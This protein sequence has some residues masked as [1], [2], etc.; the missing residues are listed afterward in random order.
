MMIKLNPPYTNPSQSHALCAHRLQLAAFF[1]LFF[2]AGH[3][4]CN[5]GVETMYQMV[6][7]YSHRYK[8]ILRK[9]KVSSSSTETFWKYQISDFLVLSCLIIQVGM[10]SSRSQMLPGNWFTFLRLTLW[11]GTL[12]QMYFHAAISWAK[13][14]M[15][16]R[17]NRGYHFRQTHVN[18]PTDRPAPYH[19]LSL[20]KSS[21]K[22]FV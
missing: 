17:Q 2:L 20:V 4:I 16:N 14:K 21:P 11:G 1:G 3:L 12:W 9:C 13:W 8:E 19:T 7:G 15:M 22:P 10:V 18:I 5:C 6:H